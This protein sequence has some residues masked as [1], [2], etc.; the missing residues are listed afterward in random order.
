MLAITRRQARQ[1]RAI[2]RRAFGNFRGPGSALGF[3]ADAGGL[4]VKA[5]SADATVAVE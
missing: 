2:L 5:M 3:I 1:L 4:L